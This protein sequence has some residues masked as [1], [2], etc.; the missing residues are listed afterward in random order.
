MNLVTVLGASGFIGARLSQ[1][2]NELGYECFCP[3]RGEDIA[4]R[5]LGDV[6]Y[7]IGLTADFRTR[8][9][10]TIE[11]HVSELSRVLQ[12]NNFDSLL[13]LS[14]ARV[15]GSG[16]ETV[17]NAEV[18]VR[19]A[20]PDHLYNISKLMGES[21]C[22]AASSRTRVVRLSNV[23]GGDVSSEN[24]LT[25]IIKE[26]LN[27]GRIRFQTSLDSAKD[28]VSVSDAVDV[29]IK[30]AARGRER[31]YNVASG[32]NVSNRELAERI[33]ELSGCEIEVA[34]QAP[35]VTFPAIDIKRVQTEFGIK[36]ASVLDDMVQLLATF[37]AS[38]GEQK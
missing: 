19:P 8:P 5:A 15:Y 27:T 37:Q 9:Y 6:I 18:K 32:S 30:I 16:S 10:D 24:F 2:L 3:T 23:Y 11:A 38:V 20:D 13:Y 28:Y 35:T 12:R 36:A 21:L 31:I 22:L 26:A 29:L 25:S 7:C 4:N 14:S 1:R 34:D 17:E 33:R